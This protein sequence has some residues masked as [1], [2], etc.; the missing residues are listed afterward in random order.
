MHWRTDST[1]LVV[2][3]LNVKGVGRWLIVLIK[4]WRKQR[5]LGVES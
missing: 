5:E 4:D 3:Q 1:I 2:E